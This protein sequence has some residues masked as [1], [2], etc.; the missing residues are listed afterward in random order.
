[1]LD[2]DEAD[3]R[4]MAGEAL[5]KIDTDDAAR[6]LQPQ[7]RPETNLLRKLQIAEL[8]GR[9]GIRDGY[10]YA[11]EH[12]SE[13]D[14]REQAIS[15]LAAIREP[16]TINKLREVLATSNDVEWNSA[17]VRGL[18]RL[19]ARDLAPQFLEMAQDSSSPL[20]PSAL[21]A[22]GDLHEPKALP[23]VRAGL[24]S[25]STEMLTASARAAGNLAGLPDAKADDVRVQLASLLTDPQAPQDARAAA[26]DSLLALD[27]PRLDG[28]LAKAEGDAGLEESDLLNRIE[29]LLHQRKVRLT[30]P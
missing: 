29:Q 27:D 28:A 2:S 18:G 14:L 4:W 6:A 22:L 10:P 26:L 11:I 30:L 9:H 23:I 19:G 7:L 21:V 17:A 5:L 8:L 1:M 16:G 13:P 12:M 15:A 24:N 20:A 25:R 3:V